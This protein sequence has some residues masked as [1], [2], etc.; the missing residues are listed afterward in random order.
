ML[1]RTARSILDTVLF[2]NQLKPAKKY[3]FNNDNVL[4]NIEYHCFKYGHY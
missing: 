4:L 3:A 2:I 1:I